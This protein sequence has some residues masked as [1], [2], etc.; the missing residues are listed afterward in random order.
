MQTKRILFLSGLDF[1]EKSIQVIRKTPEAYRDA[2]WYVEYIVGRDNSVKDNYFYENIVEI[3]GIHVERFNIPLVKLSNISS[4][5][6]L[7]SFIL[8]LRRYI[9]ILLLIYKGR[10][11]L[12]EDNFDV[13]YGYEFIG[14]L[15]AKF[16]KFCGYT[17]KAKIIARFQG[18]LYVKEWIRNRKWQ[19]KIL[20][21]D[22]LVA[23]KSKSD[24]CIMTNDGSQGNWV[25]EQLKSKHCHNLLFVSNGVDKFPEVE[26]FDFKHISNFPCDVKDKTILISVSRLDP[27]KGIDHNLEVVKRLIFDYHMENIRYWIVGE[28]NDKSRLENIVRKWNLTNYVIFWGAVHHEH[29]PA[30]LH[31]AKVFLSMYLSTNVGNPL[32]EAIRANKF[33]LTLSNGD[34]GK[35]ITHLKT[36]LIYTVGNDRNITETEYD[37]MAK[38]LNQMLLHP[39]L[40][41]NIL[42]NLKLAEEKM[43]WTWEARFSAELNQVE[44]L[45]DHA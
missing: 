6:L 10:K 25:L 21:W 4:N 38:D 33:I 20:D 29:I 14:F 12:I 45:L 36:G 28:G 23:L 13:V 22:Y 40:M 42:S 9:C 30:L 39:S 17:K 43:L 7:D 15:A 19:H 31:F 32:L 34:T 24:L 2:G 41:K 11:K 8:R 16:L 44:L 1:K 26:T 37:Q 27:A 35:W 18:V 5:R 3:K